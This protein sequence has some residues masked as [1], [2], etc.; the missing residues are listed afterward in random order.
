MEA[1]VRPVFQSSLAAAFLAM[2][3]VADAGPFE[4][5]KAAYQ[6]H[7][8]ATALQDWRP[9]ADHGDAKAQ[10]NLGNMYFNGH[11]VARDYAEAVKW[12]RLAADQGNVG[13]QD[14]LALL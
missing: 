3:S 6:Q 1:T 8:Y 9:L 10:N 13:A 12:Y 11:G 7:D 4:D 2:A 14:N 5:G